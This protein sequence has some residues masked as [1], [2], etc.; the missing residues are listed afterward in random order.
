MVWTLSSIGESVHPHGTR[1]LV[2]GHVA[3]TATVTGDH[4]TYTVAGEGRV[5][6]HADRVV[7]DISTWG[8]MSKSGPDVA[9]IGV[10]EFDDPLACGPFGV[11]GA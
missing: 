1:H 10:P 11:S 3:G 8:T 2:F 7:S 5:L 9:D 6:K 4:R